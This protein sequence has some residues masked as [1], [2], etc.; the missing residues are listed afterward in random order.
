MAC[1]SHSPTL[2]VVL[3]TSVIRVSRLWKPVVTAYV[4]LSQLRGPRTERVQVERVS[5]YCI[6]ILEIL[7]LA[8]ILALCCLDA[9]LEFGCPV[10]DL[11]P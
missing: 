3:P 7:D 9:L 1:M 10:S 2:T 5:S 11:S 4:G 8:R 6:V